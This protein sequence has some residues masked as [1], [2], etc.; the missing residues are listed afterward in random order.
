MTQA[1]ERLCSLLLSKMA[2]YQTFPRRQGETVPHVLNRAEDGRKSS[3]GR[4]PSRGP[5]TSQR[6]GLEGGRH[7]Y[8]ETHTGVT[9]A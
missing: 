7:V 4:E 5:R 2:S 8:L 9:I 1:A 6:R 3:R